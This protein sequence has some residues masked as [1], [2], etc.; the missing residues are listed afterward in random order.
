MVEG[1][2]AGTIGD[3]DEDVLEVVDQIPPARALAYG[4]VARLLGRGGPRQVG[5]VMSRYAGSSPWWRVVRADGSLPEQ[6]TARAREHWRAESM[7]LVGGPMTGT[8]IDL[9]RARWGAEGAW[10][11]G[12]G[13]SCPPPAATTG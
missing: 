6:L 2:G 8:R 4:D 9:A 11:P 5:S 3:F 10:V 12:D 7:P 1:A 13:S